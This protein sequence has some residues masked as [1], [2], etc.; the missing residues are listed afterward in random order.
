MMAA[1]TEP[2]VIEG[3]VSAMEKL[4]EDLFILS[5]RSVKQ[6]LEKD[7]KRLQQGER[8]VQEYIRWYT[9]AEVED[10]GCVY[11]AGFVGGERRCVYSGADPGAG[12]SQDR[13]A[14]F[15]MTKDS[16]AAG[17]RRDLQ[18]H[19]LRVVGFRGRQR[20]RGS[21]Q[22]GQSQ[23]TPH[24]LNTPLR[25]ETPGG[26]LEADRC[27]PLYP[28]ILD[29]RSF[30]ANLVELPIKIFDVVLGMDWL[31]RHHA[32]IDC[33]RR[34]VTFNEP[35]KE[36]FIYRACKSSYF[37]STISSARAK[38]LMNAGC[39][40]YLASV[41]VTRRAA[42]PFEEIPIVR[43]FPDVFPAE[44]LGMPQDREIEFFIELV[45]GTVLISKA[46]YH[47]TFAELKEL[48]A[49]LEDLLDKG[50]IRP[51]MS[52]WGA[53]VL[54][55]KKKDGSLR[56]CIDYR[57]LNKSFHSG[58]STPHLLP[59]PPR[60]PP[61]TAAR[62]LVVPCGQNLSSLISAETAA[63]LSAASIIFH[64]SDPLLPAPPRP[65]RRRTDRIPP[66]P[67][68]SPAPA[69]LAVPDPDAARIGSGAATLHDLSA[70]ARHLL[71][72]PRSASLLPTI[73]APPV[74]T[75]PRFSI[76][77]VEMQRIPSS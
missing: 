59:P 51:S 29:D 64:S 42:P 46:P 20:S 67:R 76:L 53:P 22:Q 34:T 3:W 68:T 49:Q 38:R 17:V 32:T 18:D 58:S 23:R 69:A 40:A 72:P 74:A 6:K 2:W 14:R 52:P 30:L 61:P 33:E 25:I 10:L 8:S 65:R 15:Q 28:V 9:S 12:Q 11:G 73:R 50:F 70:L 71:S 13:S 41:D 44:L 75:L 56:L 27:I 55:V 24:P 26:D 7:L 35:D 37:I 21:R 19:A 39:V 47:M 63:A 5:R 66:S 45:P 54:F 4:F 77:A 43:E 31:T 60:P 57:E 62:H 1:Y 16:R 48:K 36:V